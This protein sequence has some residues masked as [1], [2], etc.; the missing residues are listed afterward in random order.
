MSQRKSVIEDIIIKMQ[1][2][3]A[4]IDETRI[5]RQIGGEDA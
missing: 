3:A 1:I 4:H 5:S 2:V